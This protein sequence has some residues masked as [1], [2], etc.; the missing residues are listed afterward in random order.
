MKPTGIT[1]RMMSM[2]SMSGSLKSA[3]RRSNPFLL[4]ASMALWPVKA[5][6]TWYPSFS[7]IIRSPL[8]RLVS[9]SITRISGAFVLTCSWICSMTIPPFPDLP[10]TLSPLCPVN[11][12]KSGPLESQRRP[13]GM[14]L[15]YIV[16]SISCSRA[17][18]T[19][20]GQKQRNRIDPYT[21]TAEWKP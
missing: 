5:V 18:K 7:R 14:H 17:W 2:P 12:A 19:G 1:S 13:V 3:T 4:R 21:P 16:F 10:G 20:K 9:S 6:S 8:A 15:F 11:Q